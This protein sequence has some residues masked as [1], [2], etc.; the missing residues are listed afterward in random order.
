MGKVSFD[1]L[2]AVMARATQSR[3]GEH[4]AGIATAS[5]VE[6]AAAQYVLVH[7]AGAAAWTDQ[8]GLNENS[9]VLLD[10]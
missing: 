3:S 7:Q 1:S 6:R 8:H 10:D 2:A 5:D 4:L 9:L